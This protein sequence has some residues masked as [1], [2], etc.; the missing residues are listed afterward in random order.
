MCSLFYIDETILQKI[1]PLVQERDKNSEKVEPGH[2]IR[3]TQHAWIL[4]WNGK[5][6]C[7]SGMK[8]GYPGIQKTGVLIN[9]RAESVL[10][11]R[12][13]SDGIRHNRAII[14]VKYFYEWNQQKEKNTFERPDGQ[15]LYLAGF[16]DII[17]NEERFVILTT[18]ANESMRH[19][20]HRMP[21]ILEPEQI[22]D[23]L[24]DEK[25]AEKML[26]QIP[27]ELKRK[28]DYEQMTLFPM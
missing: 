27:I 24:R 26:R 11:K 13:F 10:E 23:W 20:H 21:L 1:K 4:E 15:I 18:E 12:I 2:D 3:P 22:T 28:A 25:A 17:D 9:A 7:L 16:F 19:I 8:W 6:I 5:G 14:P